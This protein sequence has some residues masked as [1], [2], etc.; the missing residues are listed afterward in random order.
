MVPPG[1]GVRGMT[2]W[3]PV[4]QLSLAGGLRSCP[5][6]LGIW[7]HKGRLGTVFP[8]PLPSTRNHLGC[9]SGF[10]EFLGGGDRKESL[11]AVPDYTICAFY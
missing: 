3:C 2:P 4:M 10:V 7:L 9:L 5:V 1:E 6:P 8:Q 11:H